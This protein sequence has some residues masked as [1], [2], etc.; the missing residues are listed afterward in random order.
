MLLS[1]LSNKSLEVN[2][3][4]F[5]HPSF[6]HEYYSL[7]LVSKCIHLHPYSHHLLVDL[8]WQ[9]GSIW[10]FCWSRLDRFKVLLT[11]LFQCIVA[12]QCHIWPFL[13]YMTCFASC[14]V[15]SFLFL[16]NVDSPSSL[17]FGQIQIQK[18]P[19]IWPNSNL[20]CLMI[21]QYKFVFVLSLCP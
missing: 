9:N 21:L 7:S 2:N 4:F 17:A 18:F 11:L 15:S 1:I 6:A 3:V 20:V 19:C 16:A 5:L 12:F 10:L 14:H 8:R 13:T